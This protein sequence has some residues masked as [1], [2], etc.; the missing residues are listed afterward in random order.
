[1]TAA[2]GERLAAAAG[3]L[4]QLCVGI[5]PHPGL[6]QQWGLSDDRD[7]LAEFT[8]RCVEAFAGRVA[9]VKPQVAFFERHGALGFSVLEEAIGE[10]RERGT[11]VVADAKRGDI[12]STMA[13]YADA[14]LRPG[15]PLQCDALTV[16]PYLGVGALAPAV[17][18]AV[19]AGAGL[20]VL[21]ATSNP[22]A[23]AIQ[24]QPGANAETLAG[25]VV[26]EVA[27]LAAINGDRGEG[28]SDF[29]VVVG[30]TLS[31]PPG[32]ADFP[33]PILLPGIGAQGASLS[34]IERVVA[35][36]TARALP[37]VSRAVLSAGPDIEA[38]AERVSQFSYRG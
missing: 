24:R 1:M 16:S 14:W 3:E 15:S 6:L 33:G 35:G 19:E 12:G 34:D 11:L 13:G 26:A 9:L 27:K 37:N 25:D 21:A 8:G 2:F 31:D 4:G 17:D 22:E 28:L 36:N 10:L 30:A 18:A 7:G 32:L 23:G 38:L 29:G 20:F 5:D